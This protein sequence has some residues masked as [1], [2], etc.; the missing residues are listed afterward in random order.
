MSF[1]ANVETDALRLIAFLGKASATASK[2]DLP[3]T[4]AAIN[5]I[6]KSPKQ[7][8]TDGS[9]QTVMYSVD[10]ILGMIAKVPE[11]AQGALEIATTVLA[12]VA[13]V[14]PDIAVGAEILFGSGLFSE[15]LPA[16][17]PDWEKNHESPLQDRI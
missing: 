15:H 2:I 14:E 8:L 12:G 13:S 17:A 6:V 3:T 16:D 7:S 4:L 11:P 5:D 1:V 10:D 9:V